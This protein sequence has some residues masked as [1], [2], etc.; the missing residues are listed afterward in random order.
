NPKRPLGRLP[1]GLTPCLGRAWPGHPRIAG[2][3]TE[4]RGR[5]GQARPKHEFGRSTR[6]ENASK[7]PQALRYA[8]GQTG[9][10]SRAG[11]RILQTAIF[12]FASEALIVPWADLRHD[13][14]VPATRRGR[15][16]AACPPPKA[17][18]T[19]GN[20]QASGTAPG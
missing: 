20:A 3:H 7:S 13:A 1:I 5:P 16:W 4:K 2:E 8:T 9:R 14:G 15:V 11:A 18:P 12:P 19:P 10:L 17:Q 6:T